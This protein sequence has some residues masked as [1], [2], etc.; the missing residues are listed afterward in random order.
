VKN[1]NAL[2]APRLLNICLLILLLEEIAFGVKA[3]GRAGDRTGGLGKWGLV[4]QIDSQY[5]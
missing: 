1:R 5:L 3:V 2:A 4:L